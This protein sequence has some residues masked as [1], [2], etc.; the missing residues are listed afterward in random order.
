MSCISYVWLAAC[1]ALCEAL[2]IIL[3]VLLSRVVLKKGQSPQLPGAENAWG[4]PQVVSL[5]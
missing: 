5:W 3:T 1:V 4:N 2:A